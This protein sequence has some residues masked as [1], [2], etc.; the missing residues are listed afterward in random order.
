MKN[1]EKKLCGIEYAKSI[2]GYNAEVVV[3][4]GPDVNDIKFPQDWWI[5]G[6]EIH[7]SEVTNY[8]M[9]SDKCQEKFFGHNGH[10]IGKVYG[11]PIGDYG[12]WYYCPSVIKKV[13]KPRDLA[14]RRWLVF[15]KG[16]EK[17]EKE[18]AE[19]QAKID[20]IKLE[21]KPPEVIGPAIRHLDL[22]D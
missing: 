4:Y 13:R 16:I 9:Y 19:I 22:E 21:F 14:A 18:I 11:H 12:H 7:G 10:G 20:A 3:G 15:G 5:V 6:V 17:H 1:L 2:I 8:L